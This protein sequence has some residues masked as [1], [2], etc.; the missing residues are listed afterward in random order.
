MKGPASC[1]WF[2]VLDRIVTLG[3]PI[4]STV[5]IP[6]PSHHL[7]VVSV[8]KVLLDQMVFSPIFLGVFFTYNGIMEGL[9][10]EGIRTKFETVQQIFGVLLIVS[11][12]TTLRY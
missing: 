5:A 10:Y 11:P 8:Q 2:R 4:A 12:R 3:S 6:F 7:S 1:I 9:A